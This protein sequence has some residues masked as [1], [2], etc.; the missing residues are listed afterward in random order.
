M[1]KILQKLQKTKLLVSDGAWGTSLQEKGLQPG[2]CPELW[3][4]D[5]RNVVLDIARGYVEAGADIILTNSFGANRFKLEHYALAE[6]EGEL[7]RAAAEISRE[8][9]GDGALVLGSVGPTGKMLL[10][11]DVSEEDLYGAFAEQIV[12]LR[13]GGVDGICVETV[14]AIDEAILAVKAARENTDLDVACT[15][16]FERTVQ[17][18]YR[19]MMGVSPEDAA[20][21]LAE[22][23]ADIIGANCGNGMKEMAGIVAHLRDADPD[24]PVLVHA[25][26]GR[27]VRVDGAY[28][29]PETPE[30]MKEYVADVIRNGANIV[31]GCCGTTPAHIR[32]IADVVREALGKETDT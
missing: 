9:A 23:G 24:T 27:P 5:R 18:E 30:E 7:N 1:K 31:G 25:N 20:K 22:A 29:F 2:D 19:T 11:G 10:M 21:A 8:A 6:R 12:A 14:S 17:G 13:D 15:F 4:V 16:T 26:A 28:V 3:N 32:A